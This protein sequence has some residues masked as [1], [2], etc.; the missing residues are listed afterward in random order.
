MCS[1]LLDPADENTPLLRKNVVWDIYYG[2]IIPACRSVV[3]SDPYYTLFL[4][5]S[6]MLSPSL[7]FLGFSFIRKHSSP[8]AASSAS[9]CSTVPPSH[10][11]IRSLVYGAP[12]APLF[13]QAVCSFPP[14]DATTAVVAA[15]AKAAPP[16]MAA[17]FTLPPS[18]S[19]SSSSI[20][21]FAFLAFLLPA[22]HRSGP[23]PDEGLGA[24]GMSAT[25]RELYCKAAVSASGGHRLARDYLAG[26]AA[27]TTADADLVHLALHHPVDD[28]QKDILSLREHLLRC[29]CAGDDDLVAPPPEAAAVA[30]GDR[31]APSRAETVVRCWLYDSMCA[32]TYQRTRQHRGILEERATYLI[33]LGSAYFG[34]PMEELQEL[35]QVVLM[36]AS[37]K[38][39]TYSVLVPQMDL[40]I[41]SRSCLHKPKKKDDLLAHG[42]LKKEEKA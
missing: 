28:V 30:V 40:S 14:S 35:W 17:S 13:G 37:L 26:L 10:K 15:A 16:Y 21:N 19:S 33:D 3:G 41:Q 5:H 8:A 31:S 11:W 22:S 12:H 7:S 23:P 36:E 4:I 2:A 29:W 32:A 39:Q 34:V 38:R 25:T 1:L 18:S 42:R 27:A 20:F 24:A 9:L 6:D